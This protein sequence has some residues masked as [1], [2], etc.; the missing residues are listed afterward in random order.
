MSELMPLGWNP[1]HARG[2][3]EERRRRRLA[4][5]SESMPSRRSLRRSPRPCARRLSR[6]DASGRGVSK[7][8]RWYGLARSDMG[9]LGAPR[10]KASRSGSGSMRLRLERG[11]ARSDEGGLGA[12]RVKASRSNAGGLRAYR[13]GVSI[14]RP[15]SATIPGFGVNHLLASVDEPAEGLLDDAAATMRSLA[16]T[17]GSRSKRAPRTRGARWHGAHRATARRAL[18]GYA[19][20]RVARRESR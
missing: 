3:V 2:K 11:F 16:M 17:S 4:V 14:S 15:I 5:M 7:Q 12:P 19:K 13:V 20:K 9:G 6:S 1:R 10:V 8:R 18:L